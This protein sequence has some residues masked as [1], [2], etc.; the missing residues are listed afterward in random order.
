MHNMKNKLNRIA[1][2]AL[3]L[4]LAVSCQ[5]MKRPALGDYPPDTNPVGG[6][7]K[8]YAAYDGT[9]NDPCVTRWT[10]SVPTSPVLTL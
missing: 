2:A 8:F 3:F 9:S 5:K 4:S 6:P 7:L 10:V 1:M